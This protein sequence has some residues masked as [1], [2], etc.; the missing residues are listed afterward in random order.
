MLPPVM[1]QVMF[2]KALSQDK[3]YSL[4]SGAVFDSYAT[5]NYITHVLAK[6]LG[7]KEGHATVLS[8]EGFNKNITEM[9]TVRY[10]VPVEDISGK[11]HVFEC[12]GIDEITTPENLPDHEGYNAL[13]K[14][15]VIRPFEV[16]MPKYIDLM[17]SM[18]DSEV[19]PV[20]V[21]TIEKMT[22]FENCFGKTFGGW[23]PNLKFKPHVACYSTVV[24]EMSES[25][26]ACS[27]AMKTVVK[28]ATTNISK[29]TDKQFME[30]C[31]N[32]SI[33]VHCH[34]K[35]G[36]LQVWWLCVRK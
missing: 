19:F 33:G 4:S 3:K 17:I 23:D 24:N 8:V 34:P 14:K 28:S 29:S 36:G 9:D 11:V 21:K 13:C 25:S 1:C 27:R 7:L 16:K 10:A 32:D 30:F 6:K 12:Y 35:W 20:R 15:F 18:R 26:A 31:M 2:L 5:D 22:L